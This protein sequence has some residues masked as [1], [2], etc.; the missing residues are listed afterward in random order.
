MINSPTVVVGAREIC[1]REFT[2]FNSKVFPKFAPPPAGHAPLQ[3][4]PIQ[5]VVKFPKVEKSEVEVASV[6]KSQEKV[7]EEVVRIPV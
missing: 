6:E 5:R 3:S 1:P 4:S 7:E 2:A